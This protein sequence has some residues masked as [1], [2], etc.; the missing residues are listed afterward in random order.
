MIPTRHV[1]K[2]S[3]TLVSLL[4]S[5]GLSSTIA[6]DQECVSA[7]FGIIGGLNFEGI[8]YGNYYLGICQNPLKVTS[9]YANSKT[10][11]PPTD[12][13]PGI[14]YL[15]SACQNYGG[16]GL[17]PEV[18]VASNLTDEMINGFP[19]LDQAHVNDTTNLTTPILISRDWFNL[20]FRTEARFYDF[21]FFMLIALL[22]SRTNKDIQ[23]A[24]DYENRTHTA[25]GFAVYGFWGVILVIG[26]LHR[27]ITYI[28]ER[29]LPPSSTSPEDTGT[30]DSRKKSTAKIQSITYLYSWISKNLSTPSAL[31]P[32]RRQLLFGC[33]IPTRIELFVVLSYWV[34]SFVLCCVNYRV[35]EGNLYWFRRKI[36]ES[37]LL[38]HITLSVVVIV[39]L[40]YHTSIFDGKYDPYLWPLVG[41]WSFDRFLRILRVVYCN[42]HIRLRQKTLHRS[43]AAI[44]YD[45]DTNIIRI[46]I[47]THVKPGPGQ[48]YYLYQPFRF[49]GWENH[50][51][52]LAYWSQSVGETAQSQHR[53]Q[54]GPLTT[55]TPSIATEGSIATSSEAGLPHAAVDDEYLLSF[56]IR[57]YDGWT[58]HLRDLC[59]K[60]QSLSRPPTISRETILIEGPYG[61][62]E[63]L[64]MFDEVLLITGGSG[65]AAMVPY[66]LDHV[67]RAAV[68]NKSSRTGVRGL[69]LVW[70]DRKQAFI[71]RI[72]QKE[73]A[74]AIK[75]DA[76]KCMFYCTD[77]AK[78]SV[79]SLPLPATDE[80]STED[81]SKVTAECSV[82]KGNEETDISGSMDGI[83]NAGSLIIKTGRP[84][85][86]TII[87][88]AAVSAIESG[89]R[90][91]VMA[92][93][94]GGMAD[95]ARE[96]T[97]RAMRKQA[98][99]IEYF[100]EAFGW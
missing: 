68:S 2:V 52:T 79:G 37:F 36:Y 57:P 72:A 92:C 20:G 40:F 29:R 3:L 23:D 44:A 78:T 69:T 96:A 35:F 38:I 46:Q 8:G 95:T 75:C 26:T 88:R 86:P 93:G 15:S 31:P 41:I 91:A 14:G 1:A 56:W 43:I 67:A 25:Y 64:W 98:S 82:L 89:S 97:S 11:C 58:R 18:D 12:L 81:A 33:T 54:S 9:I 22:S 70:S 21:N 73:L 49:T 71:H 19:T 65:I 77:S 60:S 42:L 59:M 99:S 4:A 53:G 50:P 84:D 47:N 27:L 48:H 83:F 61:V 17:I 32:Y 16:V 85:I 55:D 76:V 7:I 39:A 66:V 5:Y 90:L 100:E 6:I 28:S 62:A 80:I 45:Q 13:D 30:A 24:W 94:P 51:F 74:A 87:E 34:V 63:P 10:Y